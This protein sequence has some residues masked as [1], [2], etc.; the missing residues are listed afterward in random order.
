MGEW[1]PMLELAFECRVCVSRRRPS[2]APSSP[3]TTSSSPPH[4]YLPSLPLDV[5]QLWTLYVAESYRLYLKENAHYPRHVLADY[6]EAS[7]R[8]GSH[9]ENAGY[10]SRDGGESVSQ[11]KKDQ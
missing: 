2:L 11:E 4:R 8:K 10:M 9:P 7:L 6:Y 3:F 1:R 5:L